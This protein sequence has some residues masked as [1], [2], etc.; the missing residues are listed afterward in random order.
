M[1]FAIS[2]ETV[3]DPE[4]LVSIS[5]FQ[6]SLFVIVNAF[7]IWVS[8]LSASLSSLPKCLGNYYLIWLETM[9]PLSPWPSQTANSRYPMLIMKITIPFQIFRTYDGCI[10]IYFRCLVWLTASFSSHCKDEISPMQLLFWGYGFPHAVSFGD[11][12]L[13]L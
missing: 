10:L 4:R 5:E 6:S 3:V 13:A 12:L 2:N 1:S 9:C 7:T 8:M 11:L